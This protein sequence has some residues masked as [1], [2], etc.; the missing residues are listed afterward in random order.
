MHKAVVKAISDTV[1]ERL[2][3][4]LIATF[5]F[6][7]LVVNHSDVL[8]FTFETLPNKVELA[9]SLQVGWWYGLFLPAIVS[10]GYILLIPALQLGLDWL[11]LN[12]LGESRKKHDVK[13]AR[14]KLEST[15]EHQIKLRDKELESWEQER[16]ELNDE[17][18]KVHNGMA[19]VLAQLHSAQVMNESLES[20]RLEIDSDRQKL[21]DAINR[22]VES[23]EKPAMNAGSG[24]DDER[25]PEEVY[26]E[27]IEILREAVFDPEDIP[28]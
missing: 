1:V 17:V 2:K 16:K 25:S 19:K 24:Y 5:I 8:Q 22:A 4:P 15:Q 20:A 7:W 14:N 12:T 13:D 27:T 21:E 28:F 18:E 10:L 6:S 11:V 9:K 23:L 26:K 3:T